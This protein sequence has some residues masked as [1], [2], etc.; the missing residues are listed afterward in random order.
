MPITRDSEEHKM[1]LQACGNASR[2]MKVPE[3]QR[4]RTPCMKTALNARRSVIHSR[5]H[6]S[7]CNDHV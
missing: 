5:S 6:L 1:P 2:W 4:A 3:E 7:Q